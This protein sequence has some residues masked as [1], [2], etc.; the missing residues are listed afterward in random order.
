MRGLIIFLI[1]VPLLLSGCSSKEKEIITSNAITT[2]IT[3]SKDQNY[4]ESISY[5]A[6][7]ENSG[8]EE[9]HII[10]VEPV[11]NGKMKAKVNDLA[12]NIVNLP[13]PAQGN[14][15]VQGKLNLASEKVTQQESS[16]E[17][18]FTGLNL[19]LQNGETLYVPL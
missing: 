5:S 12:P 19:K 16:K 9:L 8:K 1:M 17:E 11:L 14:A 3:T 4:I 15:L 6:S 2:T 7:L 18:I 13:L 10:E